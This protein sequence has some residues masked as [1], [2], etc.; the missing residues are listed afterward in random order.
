MWKIRIL[1]IL[2]A[3]AVPHSLETSVYSSTES[4]FTRV[5]IVSVLW[6]VSQEN[7]HVIT[8]PYS[9][10]QFEFFSIRTIFLSTMVFLLYMTFIYFQWRFLDC[11]LSKKSL[12]RASIVAL[13]IQIMVA[14]FFSFSLDGW[15]INITYP[16]PIFQ[17]LGTVIVLRLK[18][19]R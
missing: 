16:I 10:L 5:T 12:L 4:S 17:L 2:I 3:V 15:A 6:I 7:G 19:S 8:G 1:L 18:I 14:G 11:A 13:I 9:I